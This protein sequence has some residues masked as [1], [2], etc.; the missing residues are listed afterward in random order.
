[1]DV[2]PG[3]ETFPFNTWTIQTGILATVALL[4]KGGQVYVCGQTV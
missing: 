4:G 2:R 3:V 1:M